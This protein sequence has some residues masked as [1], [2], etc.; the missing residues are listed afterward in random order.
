M[1]NLFLAVLFI[2]VSDYSVFAQT[3]SKEEILKYIHRIY[4]TTNC[5]YLSNY[6]YDSRNITWMN[7]PVGIDRVELEYDRLIIHYNIPEENHIYS[8]PRSASIAG[9][10]ILVEEKNGIQNLDGDWIL[11]TQ[12][13]NSAELKKL[14]YALKDLQRHIESDPYAQKINQYDRD[15]KQREAEEKRLKEEQQRQYKEEQARMARENDERRRYEQEQRRR[16]EEQRRRDEERKSEESVRDLQ[17]MINQ[18][19][20]GGGFR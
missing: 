9:D 17:N 19:T 16:A 1:K 12:P 3:L 20:G 14:Y 15:K 2:L 6:E 7:F 18:S 11:R 5:F 4:R 13:G 8:G 10:L